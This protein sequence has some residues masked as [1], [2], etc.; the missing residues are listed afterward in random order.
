MQHSYSAAQD[1]DNDIISYFRNSQAANDLTEYDIRQ[2]ARN[3]AGSSPCAEILANTLHYDDANENDSQIGDLAVDFQTDHAV[4]DDLAPFPEIMG[5]KESAC[6]FTEFPENND[7]DNEDAAQSLPVKPRSIEEQHCSIIRRSTSNAS[8]FS[9]T[10]YRCNYC[11]FEFTG[12]PQKI[13]VHLS[14]LKLANCRLSK[15]LKVPEHVRA[16]M[17]S[18]ITSATEHQPKKTAKDKEEESLPTRNWEET[19]CV[20]LSRNTNPKAKF[21]N[22]I[23]RCKYCKVKFVGGPQKI[24]VHLTGEKEGTVHINKC[25]AAPADVVNEFIHRR[26][27]MRV[28]SEP[29]LP[30][31]TAASA[32]LPFSSSVGLLPTLQSFENSR[33]T[34]SQSN[35]PLTMRLPPLPSHSSQCTSPLNN[36]P[37]ID[38]SIQT[39]PLL[40]THTLFAPEGLPF[41]SFND[42]SPYAHDDLHFQRSFHENTS[43]FYSSN[44]ST[45]APDLSK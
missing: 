2:A 21:A 35:G 33:S 20:V 12:G 23:Y 28:N 26:K 10:R 8:K 5:T 14:G 41:D 11:D 25:V 16:L 6:Q 39:T 27:R 9:N 4:G 38:F 42:L 29:F 40:L 22:S 34:F 37:H 30:S 18:R 17:E 1:N 44:D 13:R 32:L 24:R 43:H 45:V 36:F 7:D 3:L 19:H 15:C 31:V